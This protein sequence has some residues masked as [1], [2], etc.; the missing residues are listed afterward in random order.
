MLAVLDG[1]SPWMSGDRVIPRRYSD[2]NYAPASCAADVF[3]VLDGLGLDRVAI[4]GTVRCWYR[5]RHSSHRTAPHGAVNPGRPTWRLDQGACRG[6]RGTDR[7]LPEGFGDGGLSVCC[8]SDV[9]RGT[10]RKHGPGRRDRILACLAATPQDCLS[11]I[12]R[13]MFAFEAVDAL[14]RYLAAPGT[15]SHDIIA[16]SNT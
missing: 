11:G 3:A 13:G 6:L 14:D 5:P 15:R 12:S 4:V 9:Q 2:G 8:R 7:P 10:D 1:R 16:P